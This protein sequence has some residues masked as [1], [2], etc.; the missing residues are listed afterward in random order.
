MI[1]HRNSQCI[2]G[3]EVLDRAPL[4]RDRAQLSFARLAPRRLLRRLL[5]GAD[6]TPVRRRGDERALDR[7]DR[8]FRV[9][10]KGGASWSP[11]F[12]H[13]RDRLCCNRRLEAAAISYVIVCRGYRSRFILP[14]IGTTL[15]GN[16]NSLVGSGVIGVFSSCRS[17]TH[18][19]LAKVKPGVEALTIFL[20]VGA[21]TSRR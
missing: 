3:S 10:A 2:L 11:D 19:L 7:G 21:G 12:A 4:R 14:H 5:L 13:G 15:L 18:T 6:G 20:R 1:S 8:D 9:A 16:S 17:W